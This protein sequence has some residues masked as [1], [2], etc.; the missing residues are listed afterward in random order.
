MPAARSG[1]VEQQAETPTTPVSPKI[2]RNLALGAV[3]GLLLGI[4][5]AVLRDRLD[6][7]VKDRR[8]VEEVAGAAMVGTIPFGQR[9]A[10]PPR[11]RLPRRQLRQRGVLP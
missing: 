4:A 9:N 3:V 7:T 1:V 8:V 10:D 2:Q 11:Y 5:L 6:N